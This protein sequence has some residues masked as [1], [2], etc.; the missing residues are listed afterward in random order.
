MNLGLPKGVTEGGALVD[1]EHL[2]GGEI[3][4]VEGRWFGEPFSM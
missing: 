4:G 2:E 1:G 3:P